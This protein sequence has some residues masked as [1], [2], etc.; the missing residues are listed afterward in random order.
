MSI[1]VNRKTTQSPVDVHTAPAVDT[2]QASTPPVDVPTTQAKADRKKLV[3]E[4]NAETH[5]NLRRQNAHCRG[6]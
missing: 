1:T 4:I 6:G 2:T 3:V 5:K